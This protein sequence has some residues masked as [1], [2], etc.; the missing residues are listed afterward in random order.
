MARQCRAQPKITQPW[1]TDCSPDLPAWGDERRL[2]LLTRTF[3]RTRP[4]DRNRR[5]SAAPGAARRCCRLQARRSRQRRRV[6]F[7]GRVPPAGWGVKE[8]TMEAVVL[9]VGALVGIILG[10][11]IGTFYQRKQSEKVLGSAQQQAKAVLDNP[12][13]QA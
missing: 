7:A 6:A 5:V 1:Y 13:R 10:F 2:D 12:R 11:F 4:S 9:V 3:R 8:A